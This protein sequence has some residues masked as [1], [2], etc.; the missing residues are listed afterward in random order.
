MGYQRVNKKPEDILLG[1]YVSQCFNLMC[2]LN[3]TKP[4]ANSRATRRFADLAALCVS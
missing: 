4:S 1:L 3:L 2:R